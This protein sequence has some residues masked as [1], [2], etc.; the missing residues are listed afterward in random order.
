MSVRYSNDFWI[1]AEQRGDGKAGNTW[2]DAYVTLKPSGNAD[3]INMTPEA[4][5]NVSRQLRRFADL[6]DPPKPRT[7][8]S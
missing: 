2:P 1:G 7:K 3:R 6:I 8:R 5:R 4:A